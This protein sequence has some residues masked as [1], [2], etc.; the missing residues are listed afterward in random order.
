MVVGCYNLE[1][2]CHNNNEI[3]NTIKKEL[4]LNQEFHCI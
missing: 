3:E 2:H 4:S 1:L